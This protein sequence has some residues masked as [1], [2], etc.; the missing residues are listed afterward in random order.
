MGLR[1]Q[2][3]LCVSV[4]LAALLANQAIFFSSKATARWQTFSTV[5]PYSRISTG[6]GA[7]AP[8]WSR[9]ITLAKIAD[10][11]MPSLRRSCLYSQPCANR[12]RKHGTTI[13]LHLRIEQFPTRHGHQARLNI[14][15]L[16]FQLRFDD[17][18]HLRNR[19][20]SK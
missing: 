15:L 19:S 1:Q 11:A 4:S 9:P 8:K 16:Q 6:A 18:T 13:F 2:H 17:Q 12:R 5:N 14:L 7:E 10:V 20:R 3:Y